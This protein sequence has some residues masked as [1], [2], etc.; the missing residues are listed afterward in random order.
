MCSNVL[1]IADLGT[2]R[3]TVPLYYGINYTVRFQPPFE[4]RI[5]CC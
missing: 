5:V 3:D 4:V 2:H 1:P